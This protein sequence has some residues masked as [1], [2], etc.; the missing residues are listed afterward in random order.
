MTLN[1]NCSDDLSLNNLSQYQVNMFQ[2]NPLIKD[3]QN[4]SSDES[5]NNES[6]TDD[7]WY[8]PRQDF[9]SDDRHPQ[10]I[11]HNIYLNTNR[12]TKL[13]IKE[14]QNLK[15]TNLNKAYNTITYNTANKIHKQ[16]SMYISKV[17]R[18]YYKKINKTCKLG[19]YQDNLFLAIF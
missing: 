10:L 8:T 13:G 6:P 9:D 17:L 12:I 4:N 18:K 19:N 14:N 7:D 5:I 15:K 11:N 1:T 16:R 3:L 2:F